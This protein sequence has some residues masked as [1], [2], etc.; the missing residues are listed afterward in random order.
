[1]V[2]EPMLRDAATREPGAAFGLG[3]IAAR[4]GEFMADAGR[5]LAAIGGLPAFLR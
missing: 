4:R 1:M 2:A 3:Y 5:A